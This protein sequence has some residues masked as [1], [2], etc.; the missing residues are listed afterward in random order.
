MKMRHVADTIEL[1]YSLRTART[2]YIVGSIIFVPG[3]LLS[4]PWILSGAAQLTASF[5]GSMTA[6]PGVAV[7][8]II[9]GLAI[10]GIAYYVVS[11]SIEASRRIRRLAEDPAAPVKPMYIPKFLKSL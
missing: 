5:S 9:S 3:A 2:I 10:V 11:Q 7:W 6:D 4:I 8:D 1:G